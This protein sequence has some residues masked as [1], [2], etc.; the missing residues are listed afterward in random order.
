MRTCLLFIVPLLFA[1]GCAEEKPIYTPEQRDAVIS[2]FDS[3]C[4]TGIAG[5]LRHCSGVATYFEYER[6]NKQKLIGRVNMIDRD[7]GGLY[8]TWHASSDGESSSEWFY[9]GS[10][11]ALPGKLTRVI[12]L[13][14][15]DAWRAAEEAFYKQPQMTMKS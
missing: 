2:Q 4:L 1:S 5:A 14:D 9:P 11:E 15:Y 12:T 8:V 6:S 3:H 7:S 13:D 10:S